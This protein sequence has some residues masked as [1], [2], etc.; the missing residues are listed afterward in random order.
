MT[1]VQARARS[2]LSR[3]QDRIPPLDFDVDI[4]TVPDQQVRLGSASKQSVL[5]KRVMGD[6]RIV[7]DLDS[8]QGKG[9]SSDKWERESSLGT[10]NSQKNIMHAR[11]ND[12]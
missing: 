9:R 8:F 5:V 1:E 11:E 2:Q 10:M 12:P 4:A 3:M 7:S 6:G